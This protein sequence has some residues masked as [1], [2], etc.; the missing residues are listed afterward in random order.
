MSA[1]TTTPGTVKGI[2][3]CGFLVTDPQRA[4]A[5]Y[6]DK[7]GM[8]PTSVDPEGRGAEFELADGS[9]FGVWSMGD[10]S[11]GGF[12]MLSV[13][14]LDA[15]RA[16]CKARGLELSEATDTPVC[17]MAFA[18]DPEGNGLIVHQRKKNA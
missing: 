11:K 7:L 10:G 3:I 15:A 12:F 2:D 13:E 8:T 4:I 18:N 5:F 14:D 17:R 9:T 6:R 16:E 1:T